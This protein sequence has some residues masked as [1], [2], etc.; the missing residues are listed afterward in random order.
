M[1]RLTKTIGAGLAAI[2]MGG[3]DIDYQ[4]YSIKELPQA[5]QYDVIV[6]KMHEHTKMRI[7][8]LKSNG[9]AFSGTI[10]ISEDFGNDGNFET[11]SIS[12]DRHVEEKIPHQFREFTLDDMAN[13][14]TAAEAK[15]QQ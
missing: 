6:E 15:N 10:L 11:L 9:K 12:Y 13:I 8:R 4:A 2:V 3:C 14:Y 1:N 7:G 5:K